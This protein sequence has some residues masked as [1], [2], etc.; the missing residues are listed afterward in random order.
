MLDIIIFVVT[1]FKSFHLPK[2]CVKVTFHFKKVRNC[3]PYNC[4]YTCKK[5]SKIA[6]HTIQ[7]QTEK[8]AYKSLL[9][10]PIILKKCCNLGA[11]LT[12]DVLFNICYQQSFS[13]TD[14]R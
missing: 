6:A 8:N 1:C 2:I 3:C 4:S 13:K 7:T 14:L 9:L 5:F 11:S 12:A 10:K